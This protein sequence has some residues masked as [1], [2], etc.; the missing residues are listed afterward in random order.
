[1]VQ[2][3]L[4][5]SW[6]KS[7]SYLRMGKCKK[8]VVYAGRSPF[9]LPPLCNELSNFPFRNKWI[10]RGGPQWPVRSPDLTPCAYFLWGWAKEEV[11]R[12]RPKTLVE[13]ENGVREVLSNISAHIL[14]AS[15]SDV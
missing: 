8:L 13:L 11:Y 1:M 3:I 6:N 12:T 9:S 10:G 15:V 2:G 4:I 14:E 5:F 7:A